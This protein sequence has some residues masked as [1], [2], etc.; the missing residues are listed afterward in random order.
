MN[1]NE[2]TLFDGLIEGVQIISHEWRFVYVNDTAAKQ[3]KVNREVLIGSTMMEI[4]PGIEYTSLFKRI[5]DCLTG[6]ASFKMVNQFNFPDGSTGFF[7]L[8]IQPI[9]EG[10][11][12]LA[13]DVT[14][15]KLAEIALMRSE[16]R[17]RMIFNG[18]QESFI[19]HEVITN[20]AGQ[21][22]DLRF[23][24]V[25]PAAE[26]V[27]GR[28]HT[29]LVGRKRSEI[30]GNLSPQAAAIVEKVVLMHE[31]VRTEQ[32]V[33]DLGKWFEVFAFSPQAGQIANLNLDITERKQ[34]E[35]RLQQMNSEL[36]VRVKERTKELIQ[37]LERETELNEMKSNF[38]SMASH[39]FRTPLSTLLTSVS[40]LEKYV[41][42]GEKEKSARHIN[43]I[44]G[45]V[46]TLTDILEDFLSVEK[47][48]RGKIE[49]K[50]ESF[51]ISF[52]VRE[53]VDGLQ[54][55]CKQDQFIH[56]SFR[57][58]AQVTLDTKILNAILLNLLTNAVKYSDQ[59]IH[60]EVEAGDELV[61]ISVK[62]SGIGIPEASQDKLFRK[63]FRAPNA[64]LV[65]GT[66]LGLNI[67]Q[68]YLELVGGRI[69]F[70]S[71]EQ[72]GTLFKVYLPQK[73]NP[74]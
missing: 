20:D 43:R 47:L 33:T 14:E 50:E 4:Y 31:T 46:K 13:I 11:L 72:Q 44:Y 6:G 36:E 29:D 30:I 63:F 16:E 15:Q 41:E 62:D 69:E 8:S 73:N 19:I 22:I 52:F 34:A 10:V 42:S 55:T 58:N 38:V 35:E 37:S 40:L 57:G 45:C 61:S 60:V 65:Q 32:Y 26:K 68:R 21:I 2:Y 71:K 74:A 54:R 3:G 27:F 56:C 51:D 24:E 39:E 67:V 64:S 70:S 7:D 12:I 1:S 25:N 48:E 18:I 5:G 23:L 17:Y 9:S 66:G 49:V 53:V 28:G 59:D